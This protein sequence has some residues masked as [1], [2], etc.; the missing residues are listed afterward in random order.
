MSRQIL[1]DNYGIKKTR[2]HQTKALKKAVVLQN[3]DRHHQP[4]IQA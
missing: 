4:A 1:F 3:S 2:H